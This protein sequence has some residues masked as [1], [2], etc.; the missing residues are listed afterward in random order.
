MEVTPQTIVLVTLLN[1][2]L[3]GL[4]QSSPTLNTHCGCV[5]ME[6]GPQTE[7]AACPRLKVYISLFYAFFPP[8]VQFHE[9]FLKV[10]FNIS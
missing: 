5:I 6:D 3:T 10:C 7:M 8:V 4:Y 2:N 9:I 1:L